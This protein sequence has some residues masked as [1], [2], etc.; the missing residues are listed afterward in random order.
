MA[1]PKISDCEA[2]LKKQTVAIREATATLKSAVKIEDRE[3]GGKKHRVPVVN[4][5]LVKKA[6]AQFKA[7]RAAAGYHY[8]YM[9]KYYDQGKNPVRNEFEKAA[10]EYLKQ[11]KAVDSLPEPDFGMVGV[12]KKK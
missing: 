12:L 8:E 2:V 3:I 9:K 11:E 4:K 5:E 6:K 1:N 7:A 10:A